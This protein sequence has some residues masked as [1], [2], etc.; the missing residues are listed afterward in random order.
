MLD[1][2]FFFKNPIVGISTTRKDKLNT[3][4]MVKLD[5]SEIEVHLA[6]VDRQGLK[7]SISAD[8]GEK[9]SYVNLTSDQEPIFNPCHEGVDNS[10]DESSI[11]STSP[12]LVHDTDKPQQ[13]LD[14]VSSHSDDDETSSEGPQIEH[15]S[16]AVWKFRDKTEL[17]APSLSEEGGIN[18]AT[19]DSV[20]VANSGNSLGSVLQNFDKLKVFKKRGRPKK[21]NNRLVKA[22][23]LPCKVRRRSSQRPMGRDLRKEAEQV[24]ESSMPMGLIVNCDKNQAIED[25]VTRLQK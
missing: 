23:Q 3:K 18:S 20:S 6:E 15:T 12:G 7:L 8:Y 24:L 5:H 1:E 25:I 11:I 14:P 4:L 19:L 22:F 10:G 21:Y 17:S 13:L 2:D 9:E 16:T